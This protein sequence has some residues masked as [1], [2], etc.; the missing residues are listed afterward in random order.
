MDFYQV[1]KLDVC[2]APIEVTVPSSKSI[3]GRA[4]IL[5][6]FMGG[7]CLLKTYDFGQDTADM[8]GCLTALGIAWEKRDNGLLIRGTKEFRRDCDL[9]V[10]SAGTVARFLPAALCALGGDFRF[11]ASEQMSKRPMGLLSALEHCG[12]DMEYAKNDGCFPFRMQSRGFSCEEIAIDTAESTQYASALLLAAAVSRRPFRLT[13]TGSRT[14]SSYI[15]MTKALLE[16]F[17]VKIAGNSTLTVTPARCDA[18]KV[19]EVEPDLSAACYFYALALLLRRKV[20]VRGVHMTSLQGDKAFL[21]VLKSRGVRMTETVSGLL[22]DGEQVASF[23]GFDLD[24]HDFSDQTLTLAAL[25][26]YAQTPTILRGIGHIRRQECDRIEAIRYNLTALDVPCEATSDAVKIL[27][28]PVKGGTVATF[29]DH[30]VAM[31][32]T[33][34]GLRSGGICIENPSCT[35]KTFANYFEVIDGLA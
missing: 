8:L 15:A 29:S 13:L 31:A 27:P 24:V 18:P 11:T 9:Y 17:G 20:L 10:G 3:L 23:D 34:M 33:L 30:R 6:A 25:A 12:A 28:S 14:N 26:P 4:L 1:K 22:A 19:Y 2:G 7:D 5:A 16:A 35:K 32:F 21:E